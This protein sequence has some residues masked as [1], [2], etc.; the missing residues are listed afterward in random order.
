MPDQ[1]HFPSLYSYSLFVLHSC[2]L[3]IYRVLFT[4]LQGFVYRILRQKLRRFSTPHMRNSFGRLPQLIT[5][6]QKWFMNDTVIKSH[7]FMQ[8][9]IVNEN[10]LNLEKTTSSVLSVIVNQYIRKVYKKHLILNL[11]K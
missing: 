4:D 1:R 7:L 8:S 2:C 3:E 9:L 5:F 11:Q 10:P 6:S